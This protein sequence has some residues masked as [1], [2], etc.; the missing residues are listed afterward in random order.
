MLTLRRRRRCSVV[1]LTSRSGVA[2]CRRRVQAAAKSSPTSASTAITSRPTTRSCKIAGVAVGAPFTAVDD[3]RRD[4]AA[5]GVEEV[6]RRQVLKRFASIADAVA[7]RPRHHRRRRAGA[8]RAARR[9]RAAPV[10]VVKRARLPQPDVH[11]DPR[12]R[13]RL[14]PDVRRAARV[15]GRDR[16]AQPPVVSADV[17]RTEAG[18]RGVRSHVH[19]R[20]AHARRGRAA[21]CSR[22]TIPAFDADDD[23]RRV[24][25]RAERAA[26]VRCASAATPGGSTCR[27]CGAQ[28]TCTSFGGD[29]AFDTRLDPRAA[30][31]RRVRHARPIERFGRRLR[32]ASTQHASRRAGL[33]RPDRPDRA[34]RCAPSARRP[35]APLPPYLKPLLGGWSNL[36]GFEAGS[37]I[38]D[39][40]V[41]GSLELRM[42]LTSPLEIGKLGVS[43]FADTG[44][45]YD[46][47]QRFSGSAVPHRRRRQRLD[48]GHGV[49]HEPGRRA[50]TRGEY[51]RQLRRRADVLKLCRRRADASDRTIVIMSVD[52]GS[53][54]IIVASNEKF[55]SGALNFSWGTEVS[56]N[57]RLLRGLSGR[58]LECGCLVGVYETYDGAVVATIDARGPVCRA[59]D[60][61]LHAVI[62][63]EAPATR[64]GSLGGVGGQPDARS[65]RPV[66]DSPPITVVCRRPVG[67]PSRVEFPPFSRRFQAGVVLALPTAWR[68][69]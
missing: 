69:V 45:A 14:R 17:G 27:F 48:R 23:R 47:G 54:V 6:R 42:P 61:R 41:A 55:F 3:R 44:T 60:H 28:D 22:S 20:A 2:R 59:S 24:W 66:G 53:T 65:A 40:L 16:R 18:R 12:R 68:C 35:S 56:M 13:G 10:R 25:A 46:N 64:T 5:Q 63:V 9:C 50:R 52:Q 37:F 8:D 19:A 36:R 49:S 39:T 62:P 43:V 38:G 31:Q 11:A 58:V 4:G 67:R 32:R 51:P 33:S 29:V 7:D 57:M 15:A 21:R 30:A 34:R 1:R 26:R